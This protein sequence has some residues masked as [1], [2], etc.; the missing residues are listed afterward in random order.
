MDQFLYNTALLIDDNDIDNFVNKEILLKNSFARDV[1]VQK[2]VS[3]AIEYLNSTV[4]QPENIP[5]II[6]LDI[7]MSVMDGF[8]FIEQFDLLP[9]V[10]RNHSKIIILSSSDNYKDL[11][12]ANSSKYVYKY[13]KKPLTKMM[14]LDIN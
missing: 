3:S 2:S 11:K 1:A 4:N 8:V 10:I 6:F 14:I 9:D 13:L 12:R 5:D 7:M